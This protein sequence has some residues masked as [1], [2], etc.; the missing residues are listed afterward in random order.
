MSTIGLAYKS[1]L[2]AIQVRWT[3]QNGQA[4]RSFFWLLRFLSLGE[5]PWTWNFEIDLELDMDRVPRSRIV[6]KE[7]KTFLCRSRLLV[8]KVDI[9]IRQKVISSIFFES[10]FKEP[11][12]EQKQ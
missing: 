7:F 12:L 5:C 6:G 2:I 4:E 11:T 8:I 9:G 1:R 3:K 10:S